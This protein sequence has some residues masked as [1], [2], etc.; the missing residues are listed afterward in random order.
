MFWCSSRAKYLR[1][2]V[3]VNIQQTSSG[4]IRSRSRYCVGVCVTESEFL[5]SACLSVFDFYK[6][7]IV[8]FSFFFVWF[9]KKKDED[10]ISKKWS[11][12]KVAEWVSSLGDPLEQYVSAFKE[13]D[14]DGELLT[15][16]VD[17]D[18]HLKILIPSFG[19]R[20]RFKQKFKILHEKSPKPTVNLYVKT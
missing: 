13:N 14:V 20:F 15:T 18:E 4:K 10:E 2:I 11:V 1:L 17:N 16:F 6:K 8:V 9:E 12:S 19:H 3:L 5:M 7:K